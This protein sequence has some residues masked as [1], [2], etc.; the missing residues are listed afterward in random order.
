MRVRAAGDVRPRA[1]GLTRT[2][3]APSPY[4]GHTGPSIALSREIRSS[5]TRNCRCY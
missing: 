2:P 1:C 3:S 4:Q 5:P